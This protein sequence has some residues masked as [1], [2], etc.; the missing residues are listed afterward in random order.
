MACE[1]VDGDETAAPEPGR[2][3][4]DEIN[5]RSLRGMRDDHKIGTILPK[6]S[7]RISVKA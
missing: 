5:A 3:T 2:K 6:K 1:Q 4:K 7:H